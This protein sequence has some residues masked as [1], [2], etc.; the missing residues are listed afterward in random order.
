MLSL[1]EP[2]QLDGW[3]E[4]VVVGGQWSAVVGVQDPPGLQ[5]RHGALDRGADGAD[6]CVVVAL[7]GGQLPADQFA[8]RD[9]VPGAP[10]ALV[11][12]DERCTGQQGGQAGAMLKTCGSAW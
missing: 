10:V 4:G 6:P 7:L 12:E 1:G 3:V 2:V 11:R 9:E 5:V 8:A